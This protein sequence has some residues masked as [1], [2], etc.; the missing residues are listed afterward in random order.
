MD[1]NPSIKGRKKVDTETGITGWVLAGVGTIVT[2]LASLVAMFYRQQITDYKHTEAELRSEVGELKKRADTC[3]DD[4]EQ[5]RINQA[6]LEVRVATLE[7][8]I[9]GGTA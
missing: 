2:T 6:R 7:R 9:K 4:R 8:E 5:L 3:E 1:C